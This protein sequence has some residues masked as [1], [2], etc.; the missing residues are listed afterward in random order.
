M[1]RQSCFPY[2]L[3]AGEAELDALFKRLQ[4]A[5]SETWEPIEQE[6][7]AEWSNSG[8]AAADLLLNRGRS[9]MAAGD[10]EAA[11]EHLTA[12]TDYAPD[13]AEGWNARATAYFQAN[14]YGPS[15]DDIGRVLALNPRHFGALSGLGMILEELGYEKEALKAY[16]EVQEIHPHRPNVQEAIDR[17]Q[18]EVAGQDL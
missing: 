9:A 16:R 3:S 4:S 18:R 5:D 2:L 1:L 7:W 17:L 14:L 15:V 12:L 8:S 11:I 13:F 10:L 6:I